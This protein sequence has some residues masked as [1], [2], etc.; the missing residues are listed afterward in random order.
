[1][2]P[3]KFSV[4]EISAVNFMVMVIVSS[5]KNK[6]KSIFDRENISSIYLFQTSGLLE[7]WSISV[8]ITLMKILANYRNSCPHTAMSL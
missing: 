8:S 5:C 2:Y 6:P 1:M 3:E 7:L 4:S